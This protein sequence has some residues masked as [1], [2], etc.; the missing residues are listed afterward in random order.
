MQD[1][2]P[3][4]RV[5]IWPGSL[6]H[7]LKFMKHPRFEHYDL[8]YSEPGNVFAFLGNGLTITEETHK[9]EEMPVPYIRL[10]EDAVWDIE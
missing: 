4:G 9:P 3:D 6:L 7:F 8:Q 2:K 10:D 5:Y 1:N